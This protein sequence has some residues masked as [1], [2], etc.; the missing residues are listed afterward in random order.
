MLLIVVAIH[1]FVV[2]AIWG[3]ANKSEERALELRSLLRFEFFFQGREEFLSSLMEL[4][5]DMPCG[6][7]AYLLEDLIENIYFKSKKRKK[8]ISII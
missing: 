6:F 3:M 4:P 7:Y 5:E 2:P 1:A 8:S